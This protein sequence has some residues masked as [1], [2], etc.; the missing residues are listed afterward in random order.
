M[1]LHTWVQDRGGIAHRRDAEEAGFSPYRV[2]T[3]IRAGAVMRVRA[4]WIAVD[5]APPEL[6]HA[7]FAGGKITCLTLARLRGWWIPPGLDG[8]IH[9]HVR[10]N[11]SITLPDTT[12]H[13]TQ[14]LVPLGLR[15]LEASVPDALGHIATCLPFEHALSLW[16]S[17]VRVENLNPE[18]LRNVAWRT[19]AA[20]RCAINLSGQSDSGLETI[21][22]VRLSGWG[23]RIR[24]QVRVANHDVDILIGTHLIVQLDGFAFHSSSADRTRDISHD[25]ELRLRGYTVLRFSYAQ[26]MHHWPEVERVV[27]EAVARNL[28]LGPH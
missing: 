1:T 18:K 14:P 19:S 8:H 5:S 4:R 7:A 20:A 27:A 23:L 2:R 12:M 3:E 17:A 28:H 22:V 26:I 16:E 21:F 11:T 6:V 13:W 25:A 9:L 10:S 24:Q 15:A